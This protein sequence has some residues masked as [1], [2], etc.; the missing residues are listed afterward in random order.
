MKNDIDIRHKAFGYLLG[1]V[2]LATPALAAQAAL[3]DLSDT[4]LVNEQ[5]W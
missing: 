4:P 1:L 2:L 3:T 5:A